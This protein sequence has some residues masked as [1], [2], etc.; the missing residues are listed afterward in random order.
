MIDW[1]T[2]TLPFSHDLK[3]TG[4][5]VISCDL[6]GTIE[7]QTDTFQSS[8]GQSARVQTQSLSTRCWMQPSRRWQVVTTAPSSTLIVGLI[9]AGLDG[10]REWVMRI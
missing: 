10:Y 8:V 7:W 2:A 9:I 5:R 6:D 4:G 3:I 1:V